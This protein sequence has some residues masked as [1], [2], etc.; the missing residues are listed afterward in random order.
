MQTTKNFQ[1]LPD[2]RETLKRWLRTQACRVLPQQRRQ[3]LPEVARRQTSQIQQ[4]QHLGNL[5]RAAHIGGRMRLV[6]RPAAAVRHR[7]A[8]RSPARPPAPATCPPRTSPWVP[9]PGRSAPPAA[10]R[11]RRACLGTARCTP[12]TQP[13]GP[14]CRGCGSSTFVAG[15]LYHPRVLAGSGAPWE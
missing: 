5:R 6:N 9:A 10:A 15:S 14:S 4:R 8:G 13:P 12:S 11:P 7:P 2:D 3:R 1:L